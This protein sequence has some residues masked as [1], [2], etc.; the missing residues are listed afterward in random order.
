MLALVLA[1]GSARAQEKQ[2]QQPQP[3]SPPPATQQQQQ[4]PPQGKPLHRIKQHEQ[5]LEK[6]V[7]TERDRP[8]KKAHAKEV[9]KHVE[10]NIRQ[11]G[12]EI[13]GAV[14]ESGVPKGQPGKVTPSR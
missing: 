10:D 4:P 14:N 6:K 7:K 9:D 11:L 5:D 1:A 2:Q 3:Q 12:R 13:E 8:N